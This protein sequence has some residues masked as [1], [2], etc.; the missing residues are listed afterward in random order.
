MPL[1]CPSVLCSSSVCSPLPC[2]PQT[3]QESWSN[4]PHRCWVKKL[5]PNHGFCPNVKEY[6]KNKEAYLG[7]IGDFSEIIRIAISGKKNTPNLYN[8]LTILGEERVKERF[9]RI[10]ELL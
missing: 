6:K 8:V 5:A 10:Y 9:N 3:V 2:V 4:T 1:P 7:H